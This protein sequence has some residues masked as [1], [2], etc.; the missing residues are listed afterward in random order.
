MFLAVLL[1]QNTV[2]VNL[3]LELLGLLPAPALVHLLHEARRDDPRGHR[4]D[5]DPE[6]RH[7]RGH[8]LARGGLRAPHN[9]ATLW[10]RLFSF[11]PPTPP[12]TRPPPATT[13]RTLRP[14]NID[15]QID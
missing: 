14:L 13:P 11:C 8:E 6:E 12:A 2:F 4:E 3:S 15:L 5:G 10:K 1:K 9:F 7:R